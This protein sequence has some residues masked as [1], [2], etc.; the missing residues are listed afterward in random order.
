MNKKDALKKIEEL[1]EFIKNKDTKID[2]IL[3]PDC[4]K[5]E[6]CV[7]NGDNLGI[8]FNDNKQ[9][10]IYEK[11]FGCYGVNASYCYDFVKCKLVKV[12]KKDRIVGYTYHHTNNKDITDTSDDIEYYCKYFGG[13]D[14]EYASI[15]LGRDVVVN[16]T[17][18]SY[19]YK[20]VKLDE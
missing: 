3:V 17:D 20:V 12:E 4:I 8:V 7:G 1:K 11:E 5:I 2:V 6:R 13:N 9:C 10:L 18:Y 14:K 16:D 19:W 15:S